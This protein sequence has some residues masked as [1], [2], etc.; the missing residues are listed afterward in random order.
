MPK[1]NPPYTVNK[2]NVLIND[3]TLTSQDPLGQ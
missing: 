3:K 1:K 2:S